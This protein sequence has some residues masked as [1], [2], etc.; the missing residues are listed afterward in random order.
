VALSVAWGLKI[1]LSTS[2]TAL[3]KYHPS[4]SQLI[5]FFTT[6][7]TTTVF[8]KLKSSKN[9]VLSPFR[10]TNLLL[11]LIILFSSS[12]DTKTQKKS[13]KDESSEST[14]DEEVQDEVQTGPNKKDE[15]KKVESDSE[16]KQSSDDSHDRDE[17]SGDKQS[18]AKTESKS[19]AAKPAK[20][21]EKP[22][23]AEKA[24]GDGKESS[25][26]ADDKKPEKSEKTD[27]KDAGKPGDEKKSSVPAKPKR[28]PFDK[29][30]FYAEE[31][32]LDLDSRRARYGLFPIKWLNWLS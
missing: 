29:E 31:A 32:K 15:G 10:P 13:K 11:H 26:P 21:A 9:K 3:P 25:K 14:T 17:A 28:P 18:P 12:G 19:K 24:K 7:I 4:C 20:M 5:H 1:Y 30:K 2:L 27:G 23:K 16:G 22:E 6:N 8:G